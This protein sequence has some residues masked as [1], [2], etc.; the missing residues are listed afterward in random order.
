MDN[1]RSLHLQEIPPPGAKEPGWY[2]DRLVSTAERYWD[3]T[4]LDL[5]RVPKVR[6]AS[7]V[8]HQNGQKTRARRRGLRLPLTLIGLKPSAQAPAAEPTRDKAEEKRSRA[9]EARKQ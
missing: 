3:G 6:L 5:V 1:A 7:Q 4:W 8:P 2:P 9:V